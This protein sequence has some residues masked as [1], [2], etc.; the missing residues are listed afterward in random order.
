[1]VLEDIKGLGL[2]RITALKEYGIYDI[3]DLVALFPSA[4]R[5]TNIIKSADEADD[6]EYTLLKG[7]VQSAPVTKYV[8]KGFSFS[9]VEFQCQISKVKFFAL[10]YNRPY[11]K[12]QF[13]PGTEYLIFGKIFCNRTIRV[14][15]PIAERTDRVKN[16]KGILTV[17][18]S[19]PG[20]PQNILRDAIADALDFV[21]IKSVIPDCER[22]ERGLGDLHDSYRMLHR[23]NNM[24]EVYAGVRRVAIEEMTKLIFAYR[25]VRQNNSVN[26]RNAYLGGN[27]ELNQAIAGLDFKLTESQRQALDDILNDLG[28]T[29]NM[30]RLVM[31][32]VGSGKTIVAFL[33][34][35]YAVLSGRQALI[36]APTEVLARQH[37][38]RFM[39]FFPGVLPVFLSASLKADVKRKALQNIA[40]GAGIIVGTHSLFSK[41]VVFKDLA[42]IV[43]D[44][45]Q[46]F[47]VSQRNSMQ[48]KSDGA[49]VLIMSATPIPR[50]MSLLLYGDLDVSHIERHNNAGGNTSTV[51]V[52]YIKVDDMF[53]YIAEKSREGVQS[54]IVCPKI[55]E[56]ETDTFSA[57]ELYN[58]LIKG[59]FKD[60][61][62]AL[63]HG[64]I[65]ESEKDEIMSGFGS[66]RISV[67][68]STTVV[69]VG[70]DVKAADIIA[71][72]SAER[73]GLSQLHQLRGRVGRGGG[74]AYCF[75]VTNTKNAG[76]LERLNVLR[77]CADGFKLSEYDFETRGAG[78]FIGTRQHGF[79]PLMS[80]KIQ[81]TYID[82]AKEIADK[83]RDS[84]LELLEQRYLDM[85]SGVTMN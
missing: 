65:K 46:R 79:S 26:R 66:G 10:Y 63:L 31:G 4:Y 54:Y 40:D 38:T 20:V 35:Y 47:G 55:E 2:R 76:S 27:G 81:K 70:I 37:Y 67:L 14:L 84:V 53:D 11:I 33:A 60:V 30:N 58:E 61:S 8:R 3:R 59:K 16:L 48:Q 18:P 68:I 50:T 28:S 5:D 57:K 69:E 34:M 45:Q 17:Y 42:L 23:P 36:L 82:A 44:E 19:V 29:K 39:Q 74:K 77:D 12:N 7:I 21:N 1:M 13:K 71:I 41:S 15:N 64:R 85:I 25:K 75:L 56:G 43:T 6:G 73:Y 32:D 49:D 78:D 24:S 83:L 72:M 9:T 62:C 52:P 80:F 51:F 22:K